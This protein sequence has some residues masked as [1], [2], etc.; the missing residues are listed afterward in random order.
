MLI[1]DDA[2]ND[3]KGEIFNNT[4][5]LSVLTTLCCEIKQSFSSKHYQC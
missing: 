1:N 4:H 2:F 5:L 3:D